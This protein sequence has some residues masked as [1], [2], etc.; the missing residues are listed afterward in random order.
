MTFDPSAARLRLARLWALKAQFG[1]ERL[2]QRVYLDEIVSDRGALTHG[3]QVLR[4][5]L[6]F[7]GTDGRDVGDLAACRADFSLPSVVTTLAHT[8]CGDRIHSGDST[9][10]YE[11]IVASRYATMSETGGLKVEAFFPTGGGTDDGATLAHV[12]VGHALDEMLRKWVYQGNPSSYLLMCFDLRTHVGRLDEG[13]QIV[14]GR[15]R[16]AP[17]REPRAAC[18]A[19]VG[20][21]T[22]FAPDNGVH[23]RIRQD[24]GE[25]NFAFLSQSKVLTVEGV[26]ITAAVAAAIVAI[27]GVRRTLLALTRELDSR[28]VGHATASLMVNQPMH[29]DH[30][31]YLARGTVF[32]GAVRL[33]GL[34]IDATKYGGRMVELHGERRLVLTYDGHSYQDAFPVQEVG[35]ET[36][37]ALK[38]TEAMVAYS[39]KDL[40]GGPEPGAP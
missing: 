7:A 14:F 4:D 38:A 11:M 25:A 9:H 32:D 15:T 10:L 27:Q 35:Y 34:G 16:E 39:E 13:G 2:A 22:H 3:L 17:W 31:I 40:S 1:I 30:I 12:T 26:D 6:Q 20:A 28:G 36:P 19:I 23:V 24:L 29:E 8:N 37:V 5:E 21:L 33:Q 18:G